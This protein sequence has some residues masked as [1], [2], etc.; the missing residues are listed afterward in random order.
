MSCPPDDMKN[1]ISNDMESGA[2]NQSML[3]G[4]RLACKE[5]CRKAEG[6]SWED[7]SSAN[8][9]IDPDET[10]EAKQ[11]ALIVRRETKWSSRLHSITIQSPLIR[12]ML[13]IVF[14]GYK[15]MTTK[16]KD[17]TFHTPFHEFFYRWDRFQRQILE[18]NDDVVLEHVKL[19]ES[20]MSRE[21]Q[22][23]LEKRQELLDNGL[24]TFD[25]LWALFEPDA[26][27]YSQSDGQ[28]R[29]YRLVSSRYLGNFGPPMKFSLTCRYIDCDGSESGYITT[30]LALYSFDGI[31][32]ISELTIIP[33]H[34]HLHIGEIWDKLQK[35]GKRFVELNGF[36]YKSYSGQC[37]MSGG[38]FGN[39]AQRNVSKY[40]VCQQRTDG[41]QV[42]DAR[43][44]IDTKMWSTY[45]INQTPDLEALDSPLPE[46]QTIGDEVYPNDESYASK[47]FEYQD[48]GHKAIDNMDNTRGLNKTQ[49]NSR[50]ASC[51]NPLQH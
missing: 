16:L 38:Y 19:L 5:L 29:L 42:D 4:M 30:S 40:I 27:I 15:G 1:A 10:S 22:P 14:D 18:E 33:T 26:M 41:M 35:R 21:I 20:V 49:A 24:V 39:F 17:L 48:I 9:V 25:Y 34:L 12:K 45:N 46:V 8:I 50:S 23:L 37:F 6:Y 31:K 47:Y 3:A 51:L 2:A 11:Y 43:I 32:P 28:D 7:W 36:H 13:G 44:I